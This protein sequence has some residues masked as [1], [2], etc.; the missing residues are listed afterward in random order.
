MELNMSNISQQ[1][2]T[3][4]A[5][6][7]QQQAPEKASP[8]NIKDIQFGNIQD[9][10]DVGQPEAETEKPGLFKKLRRWFTIGTILVAIV[11]KVIEF[12][13]EIRKDP[14]AIVDSFQETMNEIREDYEEFQDVRNS[15]EDTVDRD[16]QPTL[17]DEETE[18][19]DESDS[20]AS[21][22]TEVDE[23]PQKKN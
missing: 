2:P 9:S 12:I 14:T 21:S 8:S 19:T 7:K 15:D 17:F 4:F 20:Q 22:E 10:V 3:L 1:N 11:T 6:I 13:A 23:G 16:L 18:A 5:G